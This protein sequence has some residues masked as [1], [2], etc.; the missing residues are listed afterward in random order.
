MTARLATAALDTLRANALRFLAIDAVEAAR[1][2]HPGMPMG[3]AEIAVALWTRHLKHDPAD[4]AWADRDRFVLSNGHGSMLLYALLHLTGYDLPL[5]ELKR[6]RQLDSRC[7]GHPEVGHTP[8]VETTTGPLGQGL[9][10]AVGMALA[11]KRLA[12]EFNRP[13]HAI[14]D[15]RT[16]VF[17][18][19]G[20]LME[21]ISHEAAS[22]AGVQRLS[23]LICLW[24][25]NHI[26]IDGD[27]TGW[28][29]DDTPARFRAYGWNVVERIDGHDVEAVD[30][31]IREA[32]ANADNDIGPTLI[33]CRT[34][35]GHGSPARAGTAGVHGAPLGADEIAATRAALG[36]PH[37]PFVIPDEIRESFDARAHGARRQAEW[38]TGFDAYRTAH[39]ALAAEFQRR[40]RGELPVSW[41]VLSTALLRRAHNDAAAIASRK[42]SQNAIERIA[43]ALPELLGGSADLTH[44]NLTDWPGCGALHANPEATRPGRHIHWGVREFGMAAALNG[45]ALHGGHL[46]FGATFLVFSDYARN[47]IRMSALMRLRVVYVMTH[48]AIHLGEDGPTHQPVEHLP[49]LRL[50]PGLDVWRPCDAVETQAA[51]NAAVARADGPSLLALSRQALPHQNRSDAQL[52]AIARGGYVLADADAPQL[53]ILATGAEVAL[54]MAARE[55]LAATGIAARVVSMPSTSVFDRQDTAWRNAV[56]P[57]ELPRLA[58]EAAQPDLWWKTL[59]GAPRSAV[60]GI[61]RFGESAPAEALAERFGVTV[62]AVVAAA[63]DLVT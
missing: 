54:A 24:D 4:P 2:G 16:W 28:F 32:L 22:F 23:K 38:Q 39:P 3:M 25:D 56:L 50:I 49:S 42:A 35:I 57:P 30:R 59:A 15:H 11:E 53:A 51:W 8:G 13:G 61:D 36:W 5:D 48:D 14:V 29:A 31:A 47:A 60:L 63:T 46:P 40:Q 17:L 12:A 62:E 18:G 43:R 20:C 7:P 6:F 55:R 33:C 41:R 37:A 10:N 1:S 34:T 27:V 21:G 58:V 45:I 44:S 52:D 9:A 26:S 19:D